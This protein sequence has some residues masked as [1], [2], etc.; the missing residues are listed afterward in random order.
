MS[1]KKINSNITLSATKVALGALPAVFLS[2]IAPQAV[3]AATCEKK[4]ST[5]LCV[6]WSDSGLKVSDL[7]TKL[8]DWV[9][10]LVGGVAVLFL[11][12]GGLQYVTAAGNK[13]RA[14]SA[15]RT[16]LYATIGLVI[17]VLARVII[18]LVTNTAGSILNQT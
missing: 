15:K 18:S 6:A 7:L 2:V 9:I 5:G 12:Y 3:A 13:D 16:I 11:I 14:D 4:D 10:L 1:F 17:I 8:F